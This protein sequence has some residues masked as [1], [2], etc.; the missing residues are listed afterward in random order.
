[1]TIG[2]CAREVIW[3]RQ[4]LLECGRRLTTPT[5]IYGDN[6]VANMQVSGDFTTSKNKFVHLPYQYVK[7]EDGK[8]IVVIWC[9]THTDLSYVLTKAVAKETIVAM[10]PALQGRVLVQ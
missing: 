5:P 1:M 6:S 8:A 4:L 2:L 7:E 10:L 3:L 9:P